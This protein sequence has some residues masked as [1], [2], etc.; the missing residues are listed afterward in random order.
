MSGEYTAESNTEIQ[1]IAKTLTTEQ[2]ARKG[3]METRSKALMGK[4]SGSKKEAKF[5]YLN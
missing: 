2:P 1:S 4:S 3:L 5:Y